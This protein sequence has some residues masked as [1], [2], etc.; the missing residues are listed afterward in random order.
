[1]PNPAIATLIAANLGSLPHPD[2]GVRQLAGYSTTG[3]PDALAKQITRGAQDIGEAIVALLEAH[4]YPLTHADDAPA[5]EAPTTTR[6]PEIAE[7]R[8]HL[9]NCRLMR[10]NIT[11][12]P[13][14]KVNP[15][16]FL[17]GLRDLTHDCD[18][19]HKAVA[20]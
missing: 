15:E 9:C 17:A 19:G 12:A 6:Q 14:L 7:V 18:T 3:K 16:A 4:G 2:G 10:I 13:H 11:G 5:T 8:C 1:M 20:Q